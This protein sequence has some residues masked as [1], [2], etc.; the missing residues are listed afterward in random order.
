[1]LCSAQSNC[2]PQ[3]TR[4][5]YHRFRISARFGVARVATRM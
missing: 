4:I 1:M 2:V 5:S 3:A